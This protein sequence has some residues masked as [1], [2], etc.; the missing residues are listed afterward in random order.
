MTRLIKE[1]L[2]ALGVG[3]VMLPAVAGVAQTAPE[4]Q[5]AEH[6]SSAAHQ[7]LM[8]Q[9]GGKTI[10]AAT[11][12]ELGRAVR[13][14]IQANPKLAK[15]LVHDVYSQLGVNDG[16]K[17][18]AVIDAVQ[19]VVPASELAQYVRIAVEALSTQVVD[20]EGMTVRMVIGPLL[21]N[22]AAALEP[23]EATAIS[24]AVGSLFSSAGGGGAAPLNLQGPAGVS[25]PANFSNSGGSVNSPSS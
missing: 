25:N 17:A 6:H 11:P 21:T 23:S 19:S 13:Q 7:A 10:A 16:R 8:A 3:L 2:R 20:G 22:E 4:H 1:K 18:L 15:A 12:Q 24:N 5:S 9:L 14:A